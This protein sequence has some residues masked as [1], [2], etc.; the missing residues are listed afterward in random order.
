M[1]LFIRFDFKGLNSV[2]QKSAQYKAVMLFCVFFIL[3]GTEY[4]L[5][6][7]V[8][9]DHYR[10][11]KNQNIK[12]KRT[13]ILKQ[14]ELSDINTYRKRLKAFQSS[15]KAEMEALDMLHFTGLLS[16]GSKIWALIS[17]SDGAV[18]RVIV[19]DYLGKERARV[20]RIKKNEMVVETIV[21]NN[22]GFKKKLITLNLR[23]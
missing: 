12:C 2:A 9:I 4:E 23:S 17:Q 22:S 8:K 20:L 15:V 18:C 3:L 6:N 14:H 16:D 1:N 19:G 5:I 11:L 10:W 7:K 21:Q 13:L